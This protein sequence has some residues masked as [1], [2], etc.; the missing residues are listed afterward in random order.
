M[1]SAVGLNVCAP[2][3]MLLA[4]RFAPTLA[5][6]V[7]AVPVKL[8]ALTW[9]AAVPTAAEIVTVSLYSTVPLPAALAEI[10]AS[11]LAFAP[12]NNIC[13][14]AFIVIAPDDLTISLNVAVL[15]PATVIV[16]EYIPP[17]AVM[18]WL[19]FTAFS[20]FVAS[21]N[22]TTLPLLALKS[23]VPSWF[24]LLITPA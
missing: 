23:T 22:C 1:I 21:P 8:I 17:C 18:F 10:T 12:S 13:D 20:S 9:A 24:V 15:L 11:D 14:P 16:F 6:W 5:I 19:K 7:A 2:I 4:A 3:A